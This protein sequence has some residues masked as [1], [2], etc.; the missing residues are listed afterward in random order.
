MMTMKVVPRSSSPSTAEPPAGHAPPDW[1][2]CSAHAAPTPAVHQ[3]EEE[4]EEEEEEC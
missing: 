4:E 2:C 1:N 3:E